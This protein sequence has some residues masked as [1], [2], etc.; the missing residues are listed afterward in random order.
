M[1]DTIPLGDG[2]TLLVIAND[3]DT[4]PYRSVGIQI[5][6]GVLVH[7]QAVD[8][9]LIHNLLFY[10]VII[11]TPNIILYFNKKN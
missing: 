2:D 4:A 11:I 7:F 8:L 5:T 9:C 3:G 1:A 10:I 6:V